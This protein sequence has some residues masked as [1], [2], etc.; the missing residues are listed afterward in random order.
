MV[1]LTIA[2]HQVFNSPCD[3]L[4]FDTGH[5]A[6]VHKILTGRSAEFSSLRQAGGLSGYPSRTESV[7]DVIENSQASTALGAIKG[8]RDS[9]APLWVMVGP[10]RAPSTPA[11]LC[12]STTHEW[13]R[14]ALRWLGT[15]LDARESHGF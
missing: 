9:K 2:V 13:A 5:Q 1:E 10:T 8:V 6:Y 4:L 7:H 15:T 11:T 12:S 3:V 14:D